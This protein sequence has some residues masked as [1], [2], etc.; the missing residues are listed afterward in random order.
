MMLSLDA[1]SGSG[2]SA[3]EIYD[4]NRKISFLRVLRD[5]LIAI[6]APIINSVSS[7]LF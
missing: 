7:I 4:E 1:L 5:Q 6:G 3:I 2:L